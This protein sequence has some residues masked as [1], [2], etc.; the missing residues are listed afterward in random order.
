MKTLIFTYQLTWK[1]GGISN[2]VIK[3]EYDENKVNATDR[4]DFEKFI[5]ATVVKVLKKL[6]AG[7]F[8]FTTT[9][10]ADIPEK[11]F[12]YGGEKIEISLS[13]DNPVIFATM[14]KK[15]EKAYHN[16]IRREEIRKDVTD[17]AGIAKG[18]LDDFKQT[19]KSFIG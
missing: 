9:A 2:A 8:P 1:A 15:I 19:V 4:Q 16:A 12:S 18:V 13:G 14:K 3:D 11:T 10:T 5:E 17:M 6:G 7:E